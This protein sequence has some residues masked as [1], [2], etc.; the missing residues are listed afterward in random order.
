MNTTPNPEP[1]GKPQ[2]ESN[3]PK[4]PVSPSR[5]TLAMLNFWE[6]TCDHIRHYWDAP[7]HKAK[8]TEGATV[9][10]TFLIAV[11]ALWSA[12]IFQ[13]QLTEARRATDLGEKQW[14]AQQRP[15]VGLSGN[16]ELPKPPLFQVFV[17]TASK[18]TAIEL[19][20]VFKIKNFGVSPA[21]KTASEVEIELRDNT[22]TLSQYAMKGACSHADWTSQGEGSV[23]FA[24][25]VVF[26]TGELSASFDSITGQPIELSK[27]R[28][29]WIAGCIAYQDQVS[30]VEHH[31]KFWIMSYMV[32]ENAVPTV[33]EK[34]P[35]MTKFTLPIDGWEVVKTE[36]D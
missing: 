9:L 31:T 4:D 15:W 29:I 11:A 27:I 3:G 25:S 19:H 28:R 23:A 5:F 10:L 7:R 13:G 34:N 21:L 26:P 14:K 6:A 1:A 33:I 18:A 30:N 17:S 32:P 36:A 24:N 22:L 20:I 35:I 8:W 12:W 2:S 16:V